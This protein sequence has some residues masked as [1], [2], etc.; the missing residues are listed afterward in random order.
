MVK[1]RV[2]HG[3]EPVEGAK[4]YAYQ[5]PDALFSSEPSATPEISDAEGYFTMELP[6]GYH[7][8]TALKKC[9]GKKETPEPGDM[10][11]FYG[12]NPVAIDPAR[13][14]D[15]TLNMVV[16]SPDIED[17]KAG[18]EPGGMDGT[19]TFEGK[20]L[21]GVRIYVYLDDNDNFRGMGYYMSPPTGVDGSFKLKMAE[22]TYYILARKRAD[23]GMAGPLKEGDYFGY[24]DINPVVV[25]KGVVRQVELPVVRKVERAEPG[26]HGKT[27]VKG[28]IKDAEGNPAPFVYACLYK[29]PEMMDRP[30]FLS[31]PTGPDGEFTVEIPLGGTYYLAARDTI[32]SPVE[33][34]QLYGRYNGNPDHSVTVETGTTADGL[35]LV[36]EKTE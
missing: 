22:G 29:R 23:G 26:G 14:V 6:K 13:P 10:F 12:G 36:V 27:L 9:A 32:G 7:Y 21:D 4:V 8:I 25:H 17:K 15:I 5:H 3:G 1:G 30:A 18:E 28:I 33:P 2:M 20:P 19:V 16:K 24:L 34:G 11:S 31:K 35:E